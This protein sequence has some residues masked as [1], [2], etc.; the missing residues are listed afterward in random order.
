MHSRG[1][2]QSLA[3]PTTYGALGRTDYTDL[4]AQA[5]DFLLERA[6]AARCGTVYLDP[7]IGFGKSAAQSLS[8]MR[9]LSALTQS[10]HPVLLGASRKSFIGQTLGLPSPDDRLPGSLAAAAWAYHQ[11]V[12]A[13]RV[14]DVAATRQ[15]V[16]LLAA[17]EAAS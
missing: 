6:A 11:G 12:A 8:L 5:R 7:G 13:L 16:D 1:T 15:V 9:H 17:I 2:P 3:Q 10:D 4:V 14:H